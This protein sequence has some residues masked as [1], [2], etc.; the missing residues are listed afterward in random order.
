MLPAL[1]PGIAQG[2]IGLGQMIFGGGKARKAQRELERLQTPQYN[3]NASVLDHYNRA[4]QRFNTDPYSS[5]LFKMQQQNAARGLTQG[6][7]AAGD[8]RSGLAAISGLVQG[9]NDSLLKAGISAEQERA[10]RFNQLANATGMKANEDQ[11]AFQYNQV[12][13]YEKKYNLLAMKAGAANQTANA[14]MS[15]LYGG[16]GSIS[17]IMGAKKTMNQ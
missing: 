14:G 5:S 13:P 11:M 16:I 8:R 4:L 17:S 12:A 3:Q 10:Q 1:I 2:V 6:I 9:Q 7:N 15:N